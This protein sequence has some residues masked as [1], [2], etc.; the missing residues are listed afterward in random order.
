MKT[1]AFGIT[2]RYGYALFN[3]RIKL[4]AE[5]VKRIKEKYTQF[6]YLLILNE[7]TGMYKFEGIMPSLEFDEIYNEIGIAS[8][9]Y[10]IEMIKLKRKYKNMYYQTYV[11]KD[12]ELI[13]FFCDVRDEDLPF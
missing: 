10:K 5:D 13:K 11:G 12:H 1:I 9:N 2:H 3:L 7:R 6:N 8:D 4:L